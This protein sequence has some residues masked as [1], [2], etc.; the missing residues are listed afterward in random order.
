MAV[1]LDKVIPLGRLLDEYIKMFNLTGDDLEKKILGVADGPASFNAEMY[2]QGKIVTS[3]DPLYQFSG[4]EIWQRFNQVVENI[5]EQIKATP[6][7]WVWSHYKNL[8]DL[9]QSRV[10]AVKNFIADYNQQRNSGRYVLGELPKLA[11]KNQEFD[12][13]L[14][15]HF[16]FLYSDHFDYN[17]HL[18]AVLEMLRVAKEIRIFPLL[19]LGLKPS[20]HLDNI[21]EYLNNNGYQATI[22]PVTYEFQRGGNK[23]LKV[24]S[25]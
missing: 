3:V 18:D 10:Q 12:L 25:N 6:N 19:T 17:F 23:M 24:N 4:E 5:I 20:Q 2:H 9:K 22:E 21:I 11:F 14:C 13:A 7:D 16:L 1:V 8:E 15:S